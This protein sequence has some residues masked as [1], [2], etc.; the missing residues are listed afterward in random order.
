MWEVLKNVVTAAK[1]ALGIELPEFP[2]ELPTDVAGLGEAVS[3]MTQGA[4]DSAG[5]A[6]ETATTAVQGAG[7]DLVG[8]AEAATANAASTRRTS[9]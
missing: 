5:V 2:A 8:A 9:R 4:A 6:V 3:T 1:D 7:G